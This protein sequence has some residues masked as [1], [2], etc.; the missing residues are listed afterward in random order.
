LLTLESRC[1]S[2]LVWALVLNRLRT[3]A[4]P[5]EALADVVRRVAIGRLN[6]L[7][8]DGAAI[9]ATTWGDTLFHLHTPGRSVVVAS[10][11]TDDDP[12]WEPVP[13]RTVLVATPDA[14]HLTSLDPPPTSVP[15][16]VVAERTPCS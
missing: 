5:G 11:P 8:T 15:S 14:V 6:L 13:D 3:G 10:E 1:D 12:R 7:L 4:P 2:A 16:P 9:A